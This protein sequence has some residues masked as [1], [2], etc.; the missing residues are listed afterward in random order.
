[1]V[2]IIVFF[3]LIFLHGCSLNNLFLNEEIDKVTVVSYTSYV[4][5]HRAFI[6]RSNL[7]ILKNGKKYL[8]LY[9]KKTNDIAVLV[10]RRNT[11]FLYTLSNPRQKVH[12]LYVPK[13]RK[14][15]YAVKYFKSMGYKTISSPS[16]NGFILT[17]SHKRYKN[18]KTLLFES[19]DYTRL[20]KLYQKAISRYNSNKIKN[21]KTQLPKSLIFAYYKR[22]KKRTKNPKKLAHLKI[23]A[24]RL[25]IKGPVLA[26]KVTQTSSIAVKETKKTVKEQEEPQE[27]SKHKETSSWYDFGTTETEKEPVIQKKPASL[28]YLYY[29]NNASLSAL[30]TYLSKYT[31]KKSLSASKYSA[32]R[33]REKSMEEKKLLKTGTLEE[34]I[35]AYKRNKN[36]KFKQRI[37]SL[38]KEKQQK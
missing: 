37:L 27:T 16:T 12:S 26:K 24:H 7:K 30:H 22:Y 14:Y 13:K 19:K 6:S 32:L 36:P 28:P 31:T 2:K 21:I 3:F 23:I 11:F 10:Q 18:I 25:Q 4:K 35:A 34:L 15:R 8:Y 5:H 38:M 20:L 1:M 29:L 33:L 9:K 17:V